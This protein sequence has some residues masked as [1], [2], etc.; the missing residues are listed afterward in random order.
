MSVVSR[1]T[2]IIC[3][4]RRLREIIELWD[5]DKSQYFVITEFNNCFII[6]SPSLFF[7]ENPREA[8]WSAIF[9]QRVIAR[10]KKSVVLFIHEQNIICSQTQLD[11]IAHEQT[12]IC[13]QLFAGHMLGFR[14]VKRRKNLHQIIKEMIGL[15][16][17]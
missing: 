12:V 13:R 16:N 5:S 9:H 1:S 11:D 2:Y 10:R 7:N 15:S 3:R 17:G 14:P 8:K 4:S 6:R